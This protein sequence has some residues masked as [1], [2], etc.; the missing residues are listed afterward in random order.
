MQHEQPT[1]QVE[2]VTVGT[3][4]GAIIPTEIG[5][6]KCNTLIDTA[7]TRSCISEMFYHTLC[8]KNM[9]HLFNVTLKSASG[10]NVQLL[11]TVTC[12]FTLGKESYTFDFIMFK[13]LQRPLILGVNFLKKYRMGTNWTT[14]GKFVLTQDN[15]ILIESFCIDFSVVALGSR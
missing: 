7:V 4:L 15:Q 8:L 5:H 6:N 11:G 10:N 14:T 13:H 12:P 2:E 9:K 3:S 1:A